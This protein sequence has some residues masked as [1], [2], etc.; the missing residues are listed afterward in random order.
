VAALKYSSFTVRVM[1]KE[2][3]GRSEIFIIYGT[4]NGK[5]GNGA[6]YSVWYLVPIGRVVDPDFIES[7][8]GSGF[9][10]SS[11]SGSGSNPE[12]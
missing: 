12:F 10:I 9:S 5:G 1:E 7:G 2:Q 8:Y 4:G 6:F 11:E 3:R